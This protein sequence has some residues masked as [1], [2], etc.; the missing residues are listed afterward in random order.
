M[1]NLLYV[2]SRDVHEHNEQIDYTKH[3]KIWIILITMIKQ[4]KTHQNI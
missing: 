2:L 4:Y 1:C 3:F